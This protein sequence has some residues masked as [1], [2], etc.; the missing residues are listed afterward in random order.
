MQ[1]GFP[2]GEVMPPGWTQAMA[3]A[4]REFSAQNPGQFL[5]DPLQV[6]ENGW[7]S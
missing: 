4:E 3:Q 1:L 6:P 5:P 2:R 7:G